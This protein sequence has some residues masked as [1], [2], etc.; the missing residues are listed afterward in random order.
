MRRET[1]QGELDER[2]RRE[3]V[4]LVH[5]PQL[6]EGVLRQERERARAEHAGVVDEKVDRLAG[7]LHEPA[8]VIGIRDV[9]RD[10]DHAGEAADRLLERLR[11]PRVD[12]E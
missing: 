6:L 3:H 2:K 5:A 4:R 11:S 7:C 10:R 12:G 8:A 1:R 9:A